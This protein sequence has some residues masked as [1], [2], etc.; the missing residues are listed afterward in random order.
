MIFLEKPTDFK[1]AC[2]VVSCFLEYNGK[3]LL[4]HRHDHK[5]QGNTWG[6]PAGKVDDEESNIDAI[7]R[8]VKEETGYDFQNEIPI[9]HTTTY[10]RYPSSDFIYHIYS[11]ELSRP[12]DVV[13][14]QKAHKDFKWVSPEEALK[15][16]L[17]PDED[18]CIKLRYSL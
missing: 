7:I 10:V 12:F 13:L 18:F 11:H 3:I 5:P 15:M 16:N 9:F 14:E 6:V 1:E 2:E 8:E 4:L 17:I